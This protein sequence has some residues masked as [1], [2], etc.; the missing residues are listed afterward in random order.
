MSAFARKVAALADVREDRIERLAG[1]DLSEVLLVHR[2]DGRAMV[3]KGGAAVAI[4]ASMLRA[5]LAAGVPAPLVEA[6]HD[7]II[8]IEHVPNDGIF[9][10]AAWRDIGAKL[11]LLHDRTADQYGWPVDY[12][13]GTV[14]LDN[15]RTSDWP[16]FWGGQ[17]LAATAAVLDRPWRERVDRLVARLPDL[18]PA[19]PM[20]SHLHGDLWTGNMLVEKGKLAALIDPACYHGDAEVDLAMLTLFSQPPDT[21]IEAYGPFAAG[22]DERR[23]IYQLFPALVHLRLFGATYAAMVD[24]LLTGIRF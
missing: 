21:F 24:R 11:R 3:A 2:A 20:P 17:R 18:L 10:P 16:T 22:W 15:R 5:L 4:E 9:S 7:G 14:E 8:F 23:P 12:R 1:G 19:A 6:E 13:L